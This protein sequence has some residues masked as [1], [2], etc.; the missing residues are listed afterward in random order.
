MFK[1]N[2]SNDYLDSRKIH[3]KPL[4]NQDFTLTGSNNQI[5]FHINPENVPFFVPNRTYLKMNIELQGTFCNYKLCASAGGHSVIRN[6]RILSEGHEVENVQEYNSIVAMKYARDT[7]DT[8]EQ[9]RTLFEGVSRVTDNQKSLYNSGSNDWLSG[10]VTANANY[11]QVNVELPIH[12]GLFQ[13]KELHSNLAMPLDLTFDLEHLKRAVQ[14]IV[15]PVTVSSNGAVLAT[16]VSASAAITSVDVEITAVKDN[17]FMIGDSVSI[18]NG[19]NTEALGTILTMTK[20]DANKLRLTFASVTPSNA[21]TTSNGKVFVSTSDAQREALLDVT[22]SEVQLVTTV[23]TPPAD[24]VSSLLKMVQSPKGLSVPLKT[25]ELQR[26]NLTSP[27]GLQTISIPNQTYRN[28]LSTFSVVHDT[29]TLKD[30]NSDT[31]I[32]IVDNLSNYQY[33]YGSELVPNRE[34][35][36]RRYATNDTNAIHCNELM[37][38]Y[39]NAG[40]DVKDIHRISQTGFLVARAWSDNGNVSDLSEEPLSLNLEYGSTATKNKIVYNFI[41][42]MRNANVSPAGVKVM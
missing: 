40:I 34:V 35:D 24:Y 2:N 32:G 28:V 25:F 16:A 9:K 31:L 12:S 11:K 38:G 37:K 39:H 42:N 27:T 20:N 15:A 41:C 26:V 17:Y 14:R 4:V 30:V 6:L 1:A 7:N 18:F 10:A 13:K 22:L 29:A 21:Y 36:T 8:L 5:K 23:V 19:T 3:I 33:V